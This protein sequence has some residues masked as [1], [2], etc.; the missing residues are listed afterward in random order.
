M[1]LRLAVGVSHKLNHPAQ[2]FDRVHFDLRG[3]CRHADCG[4]AV[5]HSMQ[6]MLSY[7]SARKVCQDSCQHA[8]CGFAFLPRHANYVN[9]RVSAQ[10]MSTFVGM[11]NVALHFGHSMQI[12]PSYVSPRKLCQ[13]FCWHEIVALPFLHQHANRVT[14]LATWKV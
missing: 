12:M 7:V 6:I 2:S 1:R 8:Y 4:V 5:L 9:I 3:C 13:H 11:Q 14:V 10:V